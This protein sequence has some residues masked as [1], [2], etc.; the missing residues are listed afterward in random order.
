MVAGGS[1]RLESRGDGRRHRLGSS[2]AGGGGHRPPGQDACRSGEHG[3]VGCRQLLCF[4]RQSSRSPEASRSTRR[5]PGKRGRR[6]D[7]I[8]GD[9][10]MKK[11]EKRREPLRRVRH[12]GV[13]C[14]MT[15]GGC[16]VRPRE[17]KIPAQRIQRISLSL[18]FFLGLVLDCSVTSLPKHQSL[19]PIWSSQT[20]QQLETIAIPSSHHQN[21]PLRRHVVAI[22]AMMAADGVWQQC[23]CSCLRWPMPCL[24]LMKYRTT[25]IPK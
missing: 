10:S 9:F 24:A 5:V 13:H 21:I 25:F 8:F 15:A 1:R 20:D 11:K 2:S 7:H 6:T 23:Y 18:D 16:I 12:R 17:T 19:R 14:A 22:T 4:C 3:W